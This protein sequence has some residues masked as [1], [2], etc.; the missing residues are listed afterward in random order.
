VIEVDTTVFSK[1]DY[2]AILNQ[3]KALLSTYSKKLK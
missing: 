1:V 2:E 3:V